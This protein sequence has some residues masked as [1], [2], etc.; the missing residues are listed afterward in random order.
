[1]PI[2]IK[3][4][5]QIHDRHKLRRK[6][7]TKTAR[8]VL[9]LV[10]TTTKITTSSLRDLQA[11]QWLRDKIHMA[12]AMHINLQIKIKSEMYMIL[13]H[14]HQGKVH[15]QQDNKDLPIDYFDF[16]IK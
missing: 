16:K 8:K 9:T 11:M 1:M 2:H 15:N 13:V 4:H 10:A 5:T 6:W 7:L 3:A 12:A 14:N